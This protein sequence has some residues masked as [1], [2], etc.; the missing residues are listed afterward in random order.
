M[1]NSD[2]L[3]KHDHIDI[4]FQDG[5]ILRYC[6]PRRFGCF[7]WT[8]DIETHFLLKDLGPEPLG[9]NFNGEH[10][11]HLSRNRKVSIKNFIMNSKVVVGDLKLFQKS[12]S[13]N[14][15]FNLALDFFPN[16]ASI[17]Y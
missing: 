6:D 9:N 5:T 17:T 3:K 2:D 13:M 7:L 10:L 16:F 1:E 11:Y 8:R 4:S 14:C 15:H 12:F